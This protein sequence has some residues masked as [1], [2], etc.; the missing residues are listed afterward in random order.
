MMS[1]AVAISVLLIDGENVPSRHASQIMF[2]IGDAL[3]VEARV[4]G[5][6]STP[7]LQGW[8]ACAARHGLRLFQTAGRAGGKNSADMLL[9]IDAMD[10]MWVS[11]YSGFCIVS[12]DHDFAP[13]AS[14]LRRAG[15]VVTGIGTDAA[16]QGFRDAC[17]RFL[18][19][20]TDKVEATATV[21]P[22]VAA[23][24]FTRDLVTLFEAVRNELT[25]DAQG[26]VH[27]GGLGSAIRKR[28]PDFAWADCG[29]VSMS[30]AFDAHPRFETKTGGFVRI[31]SA[32]TSG[33]RMVGA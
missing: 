9:T 32:A 26:W 7:A 24:P 3:P 13:L 23:L 18:V 8:Q 11:D 21:L 5:D 19:L 12:G 33:L 27:G 6:F 31:R 20:T 22:P 2:M 1:D 30:K 4:Y 25:S 29:A 15:K 10:L 14:R 16:H 17:D 28:F